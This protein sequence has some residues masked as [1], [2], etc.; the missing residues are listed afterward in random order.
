MEIEWAK[1]ASN[2]KTVEVQI[3]VLYEPGSQR[4]AQFRVSYRIDGG[5]P[6]REVFENRPGG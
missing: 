5:D 3:D 1:A 4:P 2:G 6:I